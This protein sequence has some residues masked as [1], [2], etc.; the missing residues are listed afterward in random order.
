MEQNTKEMKN[1][2]GL[3]EENKVSDVGGP[4]FN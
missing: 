3:R 2:V 1:G 4:T